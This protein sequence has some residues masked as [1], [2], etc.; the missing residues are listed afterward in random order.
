MYEVSVNNSKS[1]RVGK[2]EEQLLLNG[3]QADWS[4][5]S[6]PDGSYSILFQNRS[7]RAELLN[8]DKELKTMLLEIAGVE[9][10]LQIKEPIDHVLEKMGLNE[11]ANHKVNH[12]KAPMPG[13]ILNILVK[14]GQQLQK[15]D[16]VLILEAMKME[17]IFKAT[18]V[19]VVK[20]IKVK[21][22]TAVEKGQVLV[23][24]E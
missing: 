13:M 5:E 11:R 23:I 10:S 7:F 18:E 2:K 1:F 24:M 15:G 14:V 21:A 6:L 4:C 20:E 8:L 22:N 17:N 16:P 12:I 3:K 19:A 9:Y